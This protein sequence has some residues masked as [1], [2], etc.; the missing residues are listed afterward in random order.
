M[1]DYFQSHIIS[2]ILTWLFSIPLIIGLIAFIIEIL[3]EKTEG[4]PRPFIVWLV[5]C[6][7]LFSPL[8][9]ILLQFFVTI[10]Y[11]FQ[12]L[13]ALFTV[14]ILG[15]Y[16]PIVFGVLYAI[17]FGLPL[18]ITIAIAGFKDVPSKIHLWLSALATP[19]VFLIG[20]WLFYLVLP[21]AAYSTHWLNA[22]DIIRATN[23]PSDYFYRYA[24]EP[25]ARLQFPH[26]AEDIGLEKMNAKERLRAHIAGL[27]LGE[28]E[29]V[30]YISKA[31]PAYF[32]EVVRKYKM[33]QQSK[34]Q[35]RT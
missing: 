22:D 16:I 30:Y 29:F 5:I 4:I 28:D 21:Y 8:R 9:Y 7:V 35:N 15:F 18:F 11:P 25:F 19:I 12:S 33:Q 24:V 20:S 3:F 32:E 34:V 23:G 27:Y 6:Q 10:A 14:I 13:H 1:D 2:L 26:F 17:G 31:Y